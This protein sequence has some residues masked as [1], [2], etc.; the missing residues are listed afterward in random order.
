MEL[1]LS[2]LHGVMLMPSLTLM[3]RHVAASVAHKSTERMVA[4]I[5]TV[6]CASVAPV[7]RI[8]SST[9]RSVYQMMK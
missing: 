9:V 3:P 8:I 5:E 6:A 7:G 4:K 1:T 2:V